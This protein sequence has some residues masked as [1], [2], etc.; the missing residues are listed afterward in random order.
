MTWHGARCA[1]GVLLTTLRT[2][3]SHNTTGYRVHRGCERGCLADDGS[4]T[5]H[6]IVVCLGDV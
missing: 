1:I 5:W 3:A 2:L 6:F 4:L